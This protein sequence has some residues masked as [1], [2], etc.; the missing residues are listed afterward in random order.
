[1][2]SHMRTPLSTSNPIHTHPLSQNFQGPQSQQSSHQPWLSTQHGRP[3][4]SSLRL[5]VTSQALQQRT[6]LPQ[7]SLQPM[8]AASQLQPLMS[9]SQQHHQQQQPHFAVFIQFQDNCAQ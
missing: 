4:M 3:P 1:M 5:Q 8:P 7:Q 2:G 6:L 9:F